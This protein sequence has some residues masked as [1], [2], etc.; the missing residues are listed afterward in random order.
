MTGF[1]NLAGLLGKVQEL[2][3][4][5]QQLQEEMR[6]KRFESSSGGGMVTAVVNGRN[7]L[8]DLKID[9]Q[10]VDP[11]D[12]EMLEDLIKAAIQGAAT[13]SQ[14]EM[15]QEMANLTGGLNIPGIGQISNLFG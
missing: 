7:E 5:M 13:K 3:G 8:V 9:P 15:K 14:E 11:N 6:N 10:A 1:G 12:I 2:K 4:N